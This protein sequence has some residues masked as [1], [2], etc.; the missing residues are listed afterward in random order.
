MNGIL[1]NTSEIEAIPDEVAESYFEIEKLKEAA[2]ELKEKQRKD[3]RELKELAN[4]LPKKAAPPEVV[5]DDKF[6]I[7]EKNKAGD[8]KISVPL[9]AK[10]IKQKYTLR[11]YNGQIRIFKN[12]YYCRMNDIKFVIH[13]EIPEN[14][15]LPRDIESCE[16]LLIY[17]PGLVLKDKDLAPERYI[18]F[19]N[20]VM[21]VKTKKFFDYAANEVKN[22]IFINQVDYNWNPDV[23]DD[24]MTDEFFKSITNGKQEDINFLYQVIGVAISNYRDFKNIFYFTGKKDS[25]KSQYL[26]LIEKLLT[27]SDETKDYSSIGLAMFTNEGSKELANIVGKRAN[28]CGETP[29]IDIRNDTLLK[30]LS[31]GDEA[32]ISRKFLEPLTFINKAILIF[33]GN[34]VPRFFIGDKCSFGERF[35]IYRFKNAIPKEKQ[36]PSVYKKLNME[37]IIKKSIEQLRIFIADKQQFTIPPEIYANREIMEQESDSIYRFFKECV[38]IT[39]DEKHRISTHDLFE[40]FT[41]FLMDEGTLPRDPYTNRPDI[42]RL[43]NLTQRTFINKIKGFIGESYYKRNIKYRDGKKETCY[44][45][46]QIQ[47]V[48]TIT[49]NEHAYKNS[50]LELIR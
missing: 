16:K 38:V 23:E 35:L 34:T 46:I 50:V 29:D 33:S 25:G 9:L 11:Y 7:I 22:L 27:Y 45:G 40:I 44:I 20:G 14:L 31:G 17:D 10:Y 24:P 15:R 43:G 18:A 49:H 47:N 4:I 8:L 26:H 48:S 32:E 2:A 36:I 13:D 3:E 28:I 30:K 6:F 1:N 42:R 12:N 19:K 41:F 37:Y 39:D 21:N 5:K